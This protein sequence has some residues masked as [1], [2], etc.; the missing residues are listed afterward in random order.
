MRNEELTVCNEKL[1][2]TTLIIV[3]YGRETDE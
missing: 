2:I 3:I 1:R